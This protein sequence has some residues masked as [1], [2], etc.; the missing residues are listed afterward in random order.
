MDSITFWKTYNLCKELSL[1]GS[2][3][4][5]GVK[6]FN[7]MESLEYE[8]EIFEFLYNI[9]VGIE[10]LEKIVLILKEKIDISTV[11]DFEKTLITH[12]HMLLIKRI[13]GSEKV[14]STVHNS[15][16]QILTEFYNS[17]RYDRY[18]LSDFRN[19][20]K[21]K[22]AL[23]NYINKSLNI[24]LIENDLILTQNSTRIKRFI[25]KTIGK[26]V[27]YLYEKVLEYSNKENVFTYE[28]RS[29]TKA[30]KIFIRKEFD[31]IN[32]EVFWKELL[33]YILH[34]NTN[35]YLDLYKTLQP[36]DFDEADLVGMI[37][38]LRNDVLKLPYLGQLDYLYENIKNKGKRFDFLDLI[39]NDGISFQENDN[40]KTE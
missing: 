16:L 24:T 38:S 2:F 31:F 29:D 30:Y 23:I 17:W 27:T 19:Y 14:F 20:D 1:A 26:I 35:E 11:N 28:V 3:I 36:I 40:N 32:E 6:V 37:N 15:L 4:Y 8:E 22:K 12:N 21:E 10:R 9:S 5:N 34:N 25:G 18:S 39:G 33:I 7:D 13:V